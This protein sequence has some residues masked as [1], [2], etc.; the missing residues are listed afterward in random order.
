MWFWCLKL[1]CCMC[2]HS[3]THARVCVCVCVCLG[4]QCNLC[5]VYVLMCMQVYAPMHTH[6]DQRKALGVWFYNSL[7]LITLRQGFSLNDE[8]MCLG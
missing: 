2:V 5:A 4:V 7:C 8:H 6:E 1:Y 3:C